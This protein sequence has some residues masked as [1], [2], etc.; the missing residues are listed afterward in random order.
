VLISYYPS[1]KTDIPYGN[2]RQ[3]LPES[4]VIGLS[5]SSPEE[6][7][8]ASQL[9]V[10]YVGIGP[11]WWTTSKTLQKDVI[12]VRGVGSILSAL[13]PQIKAVG[14]GKIVRFLSYV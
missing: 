10:D 14:I 1:L 12:G 9:G 5:V 4:T 8:T 7:R 6:A 11:I 2:A 3:L 13:S